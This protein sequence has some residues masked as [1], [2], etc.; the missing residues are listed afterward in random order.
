MKNPIRILIA[1]SNAFFREGVRA[2]LDGPGDMEVVAQASNAMETVSAFQHFHPDVTILDLRMPEMECLNA[3]KAIRT[4]SASAK[5]IIFTAYD[6][7]E[8]IIR[9]MRA[10]ASGYLLKDTPPEDLLQ[11][12]RQVHS[13]TIKI[14]ADIL[15]KVTHHSN[16]EEL[17][18]CERIVLE[19]LAHGKSN[20]QIAGHLTLSESTIKFHINNILLKLDVSNRTEAVVTGLKRGLIRLD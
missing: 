1:D 16:S 11:I 15:H 6:S 5:I 4:E 9:G 13:G 17:S 20:S 14:A 3:M 10:G 7:E 19:N 8:D 2:V 12:I 18:E